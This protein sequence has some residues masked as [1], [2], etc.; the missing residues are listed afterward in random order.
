MG[1]L[2][3]LNS[4][5]KKWEEIS[6]DVFSQEEM[7][8][9]LS[10]EVVPSQFGTSARINLAEEVKY[11][12]LHKDNPFIPVGTIL[13]KSQCLVVSLVRGNQTTCKLLYNGDVE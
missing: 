6:R 11:I 1:I 13:D 12:P 4:Y 5:Q 7:D 3:S 10:I 2:N 9:I 8:E